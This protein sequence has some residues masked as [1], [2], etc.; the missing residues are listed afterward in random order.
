MGILC[1]IPLIAMLFSCS[2]APKVSYETIKLQRPTTIDCEGGALGTPS[3]G[4]LTNCTFPTLNQST[5]GNAA[6]EA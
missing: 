1:D 6:L 3:S 5:T 4:T 2:E